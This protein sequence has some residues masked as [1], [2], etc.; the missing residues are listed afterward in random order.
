MAD[1]NPAPPLPQTLPFLIHHPYYHYLTLHKIQQSSR[2]S[3]A[4]RRTPPTVR[5][6]GHQIR[7]PTQTASH[8][9]ARR[10][11]RL[12]RGR[13]S[14]S[15]VIVRNQRNGGGLRGCMLRKTRWCGCSVVVLCP[16]GLSAALKE[17]EEE[18]T[19][20]NTQKLNNHLLSPLP[21]LFLPSLFPAVS[22]PTH[23]PHKHRLI[24]L[25]PSIIPLP[26]QRRNLLQS[27]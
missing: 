1:S 7:T 6:Q 10:N 16:T 18:L 12:V 19:R 25:H 11:W 27:T 5:V 17:G 13:V 21:P 8:R 9:V 22:Q 3:P 14:S 4:C 26:I 24:N 23:R 2:P 20:T 15:I